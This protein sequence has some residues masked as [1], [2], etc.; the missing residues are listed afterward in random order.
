MHWLTKYK[1]KTCHA[2]AHTASDMH[3]I[4]CMHGHIIQQP[5][6]YISSSVLCQPVQSCIEPSLH[7]LD[8]CLEIFLETLYIVRMICTCN[9]GVDIP[10]FLP[11]PFTAVWV[12][13]RRQRIWR[14]QYL[15]NWLPA[16]RMMMGWH[17]SAP[18]TQTLTL[19]WLNRTYCYVN[20]TMKR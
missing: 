7:G 11:P 13:G 1:N 14:E 19:V 4:T 2:H 9:H 10:S 12:Q 16:A 8:F 3:S 20:V 6:L 18:Y 15:T 5:S 17:S